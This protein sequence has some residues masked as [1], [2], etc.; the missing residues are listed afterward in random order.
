MYFLVGKI[1]DQEI[2][3]V[4]CTIEKNIKEFKV[5]KIL[6]LHFCETSDIETLILKFVEFLWQYENSFEVHYNFFQPANNDTIK[7]LI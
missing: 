6:Y 2:G 1:G 5:L 7:T 4:L 3:R